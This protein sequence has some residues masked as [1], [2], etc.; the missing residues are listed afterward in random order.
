M[1]TCRFDLGD[2]LPKIDSSGLVQNSSPAVP[3]R[4]VRW[5][6]D[7]GPKV[8][9]MLAPS[10]SSYKDWIKTCAPDC[11]YGLIGDGV[12]DAA[13]NNQA[14]GYDMFDCNAEDALSLPSAFFLNYEKVLLVRSCSNDETNQAACR[15]GFS[16]EFIPIVPSC[17]T[18]AFLCQTWSLSRVITTKAAKP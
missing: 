14:C 10:R 11:H 18:L 12:C 17:L 9:V 15:L 13:C 16:R 6:I 3:L 5:S 8:Q 1:S 2:C 7:S 4:T